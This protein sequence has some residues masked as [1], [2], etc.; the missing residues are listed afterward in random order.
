MDSRDLS[1]SSELGL[2]GSA[3]RLSLSGRPVLSG[4]MSVEEFRNYYFL[5]EELVRFCREKGLST[6][7]SKAELTERVARF[8]GGLP[9]DDGIAV[10]GRSSGRRVSQNGALR[11]RAASRDEFLSEESVIEDGFVCSERH[12][13][14]FRE[15]IGAGFRFVVPFQRWLRANAGRT[16]GEAIE[17]YREIMRVG[18][19]SSEIG[20]QFEYNRYVRDFFADNRGKYGL[21]E[22]IICWKYKRDLPGHNKYERTDLKVLG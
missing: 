20:E 17:A 16:Y 13:A 9:G 18:G 11:P 1:L 3:G 10:C 4:E 6:G 5:K 22:A 14:F 19:S 15:K 21:R 12:R 7:G 2:S 8:L